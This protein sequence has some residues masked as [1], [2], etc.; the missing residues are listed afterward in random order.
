M[1]VRSARHMLALMF[2][3]GGAACSP[4][5]QPSPLG[6]G[7]VEAGLSKFPGAPAS[8][9]RW[10]RFS[11]FLG[12]RGGVRRKGASN[13]LRRPIY[14]DPLAGTMGV[15]LAALLGLTFALAASAGTNEGVATL[16]SAVT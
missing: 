13:W 4:S 15:T 7:G 11:L 16:P 14:Q 12:E 2:P 5:P 3:G 9:R 8:R 10:R 1:R 6:R